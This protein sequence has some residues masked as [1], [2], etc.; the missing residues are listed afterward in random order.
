VKLFFYIFALQLFISSSLFAN[1]ELVENET[2]TAYKQF[3]KAETL[4]SEKKYSDAYEMILKSFQTYRPRVK[5]ISLRYNCVTYIPGPYSVTI[6]KYNKSEMFDFD[7]TTLGMEIKHQI[8]PAP[9]VFIE[10]QK[11][12]TIV[13]AVNSIK[14]SRN[15]LPKR[16]PLENFAVTIDSSNFQFGNLEV[17][18]PQTIK[19]NRSFSPNASIRTSEEFGFKLY[20]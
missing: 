20:K 6:K 12:K 10:Y 1:C 18:K 5:E 14:T 17:G 9:Y 13:S 19:K 4:H 3:K 8:S 2:Y 16:L 7:R 15:N 11:N